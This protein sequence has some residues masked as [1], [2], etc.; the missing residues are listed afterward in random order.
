VYLLNLET[1]IFFLK[2]ITDFIHGHKTTRK[3]KPKH[4]KKKR[5]IKYIFLK[6]KK[7]KKKEEKIY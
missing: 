4:K 6:K 5:K 7:K 1:T 2:Q 3:G